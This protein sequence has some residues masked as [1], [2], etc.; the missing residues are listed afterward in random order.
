[1]ND[2]IYLQAIRDITA[3]AIAGNLPIE[4]AV[5]ATVMKEVRPQNPPVDSASNRSSREIAE[6]LEDIC[7]LDYNTIT[8]VMIR[9]GYTLYIDEPQ[10]W[11]GSKWSI[12]RLAGAWDGSD[13]VPAKE[14]PGENAGDGE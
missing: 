14:E 13:F 8:H 11:E 7:R 6:S 2:T 1:M 10:S 3:D 12:M 5:L 4:T 9:L